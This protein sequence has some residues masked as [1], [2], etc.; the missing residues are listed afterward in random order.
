MDCRVRRLDPPNGHPSIYFTWEGRREA[1]LSGRRR[2][3]MRHAWHQG[4][5][6]PFSVM[7]RRGK[8][9]LNPVKPAPR[10]LCNHLFSGRARERETS[11]REEEKTQERAPSRP[12]TYIFTLGARS[13]THTYC[14]WHE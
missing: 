5:G 6:E 4:M 11:L 10:R 7:R 3:C 12:P 9:K 1:L 14:V 2:S 13:H 8:G